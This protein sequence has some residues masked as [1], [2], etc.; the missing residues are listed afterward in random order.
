MCPDTSTATRSCSASEVLTVS[1]PADSKETGCIDYPIR[2]PQS[3]IDVCTMSVSFEGP[4][5]PSDTPFELARDDWAS[6]GTCLWWIN[7]PDSDC[8][9]LLD[10]ATHLTVYITI[11]CKI[12]GAETTRWGSWPGIGAS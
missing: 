9:P 2:L 4:L 1:P 11:G 10:G 5:G 8:A 6:D 7:L 3:G 12:A